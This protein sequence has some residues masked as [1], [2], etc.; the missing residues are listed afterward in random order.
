MN[1]LAAER[2]KL[3][4]TRSPWWCT[5]VAIALVVGGMALLAASA[6]AD[7]GPI[8][9]WVTS[10][11]LQFGM[12]VVMVMATV[13]VTTEYRFSTIRTTFQAVPNRT[14]ALLAKTAVVGIVA[15]IAGLVSAFGG[16]A[17]MALLRPDP[18][19]ALTTDA[20]WR[21]IAGAGPAFLVAAVL[22][23]AVGI[24]VRQT[25]GAVALLLVWTLL[26]E[27]LIRVIPDVGP[28][29]Y[30]WL[31]FTNIMNFL[32]GGSADVEE[33]VG[34]MALTPWASLAY[35]AALAGGLLVVAI[36]TANR[37]DA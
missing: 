7:I 29:I 17:M 9:T 31:P 16:W 13:S 22:A 14:A 36:V 3:F 10:Q 20:Q 25:A 34:V 23:V 32:A 37:R 26:V 2:I 4:S 12:V 6:P 33:E 11:F 28:L 5:A 30:Q 8:P 1:L 19:L 27:N 35:V 18:A 15:T 24:L 21:A